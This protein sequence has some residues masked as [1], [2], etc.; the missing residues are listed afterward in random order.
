MSSIAVINASQLVTLAG[1]AHP[2]VGGEMSE[3][4]IIR[5]GGM[6]IRVGVSHEIEKKEDY[7][8][9]SLIGRCP[10]EC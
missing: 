1:P 9:Y 10:R 4:A 8:W 2:R 5:N 6:L 3:L 7:S